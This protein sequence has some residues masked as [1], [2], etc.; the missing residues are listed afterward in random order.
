MTNR[1]DVLKY[2]AFGGA[3]LA[4]P[5]PVWAAGAVDDYMRFVHPELREGAARLAE[6]A[7]VEQPLTLDNLPAFRESMKRWEQPWRTDVPAEKRTIK[8]AVGSPD[9]DIYIVNA[10]PATPRPAI[11][12]THGGGYIGGSAKSSVPNLQ[13]VCAELGCMA[14][15]VDYRLA[16]ETTYA[17]SIEDNYAGLK[18]LY[19]NAEAIGADKTRIALMGESAGGGHAALLAITARD[20]GEVPVAFQ[21]LTY[22]MLDDRTGSTR[23]VAPHIGKIIWDAHKNI[24]GWHSFLG[25][26]PGGEGI[27]AAGVPARLVDLTGLPPAWIGVG[28]IDLFVDEDVDYAQRLNAAG[29][30]AEL[31]VVPGAYHGFDGIAG[32]T[33]I[34]QWFNRARMTALRRG[35]GLPAVV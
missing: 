33:A 6:Y 35:L 14:V 13:N 12:H 18:W 15:S 23:Q 25:Q 8:G 17:E 22:P 31:I 28:G 30:F 5:I 27:P 2:A 3:A 34:G 11:L 24:F 19:D 4:L 26:E 7:K 29:V 20:R 1:R 32:T 16:P 10:D 9:V 21:C